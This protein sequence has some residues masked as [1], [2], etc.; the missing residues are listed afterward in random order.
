MLQ[1][2][3]YELNPWDKGGTAR[4]ADYTF[5]YEQGNENYQLGTRFFIHQRT[6]PQLK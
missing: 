1:I 5:F 4:A 3:Q 6:V 2:V